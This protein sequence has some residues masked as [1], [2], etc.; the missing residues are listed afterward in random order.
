MM[1]T[2]EIKVEKPEEKIC[3][4]LSVALRSITYCKYLDCMFFYKTWGRCVIEAIPEVLP[5]WL[6]K[7][8]EEKTVDFNIR[9]QG[10]EYVGVGRR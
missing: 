4:L 9:I 1:Q 8:F 10:S 5:Y 7:T 6:G 3:P 2:E